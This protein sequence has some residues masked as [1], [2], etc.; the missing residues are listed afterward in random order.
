MPRRRKEGHSWSILQTW[1]TSGRSEDIYR[2]IS[3]ARRSELRRLIARY[4]TLRTHTHCP[5]HP[6]LAHKSRRAHTRVHGRAAAPRLRRFVL[7]RLCL[8]HFERATSD[9]THCWR[10]LA[11]ALR[12]MAPAVLPPFTPAKKK[13]KKKR[14][15]NTCRT[16]LARTRTR[17]ASL[18]ARP[19]P[20]RTLLISL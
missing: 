14:R 13:K 10:R 20:A 11:A 8:R 3:T 1:L 6:Y 16:V 9:T 15:L 18:F 7:Q 19:L 17:G 12:R 5:Y 2:L 4:P